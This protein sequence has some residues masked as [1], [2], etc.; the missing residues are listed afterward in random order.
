VPAGEPIL[1]AIGRGVVAVWN[2]WL[3]GA[4]HDRNARAVL[5]D[6]ELARASR[7][8]FD[9]HR[10]RF[11]AGRLA[12]RELLARYLD[13]APADVSF[14]YSSHGK[15]ELPGETLRFNL[16]HSDDLAVIGLTEQ[17]R[18]GVDVERLRDLDDVDSLARRVFSPHELDVFQALPDASKIQGFFNGWTRKEAFVKAVGDGLSHPLDTFDVTLRPGEEPRLLNVD[19][20]PTRTAAWSMFEISPLQG[21]VGA[22]AVERADAALEHAGWLGDPPPTW[23][24]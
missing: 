10:N 24:T 20:S 9:L 2:V 6:D 16:A 19:S 12:L 4:P 23:G 15:P 8:V 21:W 18:L 1:P 5:S 13:R 14:S 7:F 17:D 3:G 22:V 11:M